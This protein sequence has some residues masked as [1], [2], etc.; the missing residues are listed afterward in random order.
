LPRSGR[1]WSEVFGTR[2]ETGRALGARLGAPYLAPILLA[3]LALAAG[4]WLRERTPQVAAALA[5]PEARVKAALAAQRHARIENV[6]GHQAGG[7]ATLDDVRFG[8]VLVEVE[9]ERARVVA[10]VQADGRVNWRS[11]EARLGYV[12]REAFAMAPCRVAGWC[13]DGAQFDGLRAVLRLLFRRLDAFNS[14]DAQ[15][16]GRLVASDWR[17]QGARAALLDRLARD[18]AGQPRARL[19]VEAWQIRVER[20]R[21]VVGEDGRLALGDGPARPLRTRLELTREAGRWVIAAG[22]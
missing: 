9:G 1:D 4:L 14:A 18:L 12:G 19:E 5:P 15:A 2:R 6:Y 11:H 22:L 8:D 21:A 13:G 20:D 3:L 17:G 16:Y 7:M 10:M